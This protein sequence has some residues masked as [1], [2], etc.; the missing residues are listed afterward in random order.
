MAQTT[1]RRR[2]R[3]RHASRRRGSTRRHPVVAAPGRLLH[4]C[5]PPHKRA[6]SQHLPPFPMTQVQQVKALLCLATRPATRTTQAVR[7]Q[8]RHNDGRL[9][10]LAVA[11]NRRLARLRV[12]WTAPLAAQQVL[13]HRL[14]DRRSCWAPTDTG[15]A[16][17]GVAMNLANLRHPRR[18][19]VT[20]TPT[21]LL[22]ASP[23]RSRLKSATV[24]ARSAPAATRRSAV[25]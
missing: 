7:R 15:E 6:H 20:V 14:D 11:S 13:F 1:R 5:R 19:Q 3:V 12:R 18:W 25:S 17:T 21:V 16:A 4:P 24:D 9:P 8:A 22:V 23:S 10:T 2:G